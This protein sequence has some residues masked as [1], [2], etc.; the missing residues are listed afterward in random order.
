MRPMI[1][2]HSFRNFIRTNSSALATLAIISGSAMVTTTPVAA[3]SFSC[4]R[5]Q[6]P[7][8]LA[9]CNDEELIVLDEELSALFADIRISVANTNRVRTFAKSHEQ[10]LRE[11]NQCAQDFQCLRESYRNRIKEITPDRSL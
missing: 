1:S 5:A 11:R 7:S 4:A 10:W 9:I 8:E 3:Q 6:L 2:T